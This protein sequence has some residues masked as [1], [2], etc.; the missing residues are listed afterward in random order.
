MTVGN[1]VGGRAADIHVMRSL[2]ICFGA[3]LVSLV[4][5][6]LT[7]NTVPGLFISLFFVGAS[8]AASSPAIQTRL[9]DVAGDSQTL[10]AAVNHSA[11]NI[12]N[13]LGAYLGGIA[14]AAGLGYLSPTWIGV[15]LTILGIFIALASL[16]T[17]RRALKR[18]LELAGNL[19]LQQDAVLDRPLS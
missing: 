13:S 1:Y 3:L 10:A 15:G 18:E 5:F 6:A 2:F 14:I 16:L 12:G 9:M 8:A 19:G 4:A 17:G 11:L 7:A